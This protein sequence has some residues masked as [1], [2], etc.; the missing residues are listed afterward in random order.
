MKRRCS[1]FTILLGFAQ[2][3]LLLHP[4][5]G[6]S[7]TPC[8]LVDLRFAPNGGTTQFVINENSKMINY[9]IRSIR[10]LLSYL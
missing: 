5:H 7:D 8:A 3:I 4:K 1:F 2:K 10:M 6:L 9:R